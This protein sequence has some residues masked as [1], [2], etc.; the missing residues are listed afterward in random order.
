MR[1]NDKIFSQLNSKWASK[2]YPTKGST[3]GGNGCGACAVTHIAIEQSSKSDWTP[4]V[5]RKWMISHGYAVPG[6]GTRWEGINA[7]LKYIGHEKVVWIGRNDPMSLA[8]KELNKGNRIGVLLVSNGKTPNGTVWTSSG[9]YVAFTKYRLKN[10]LH[11]FYIKDSGGRQHNGWYTYEKSI[12][13]ALPQLWIV[14]KLPDK[15]DKM[16]K[17]ATKIANDNNFHYVK[18]NGKDP[19]TKQCPICHNFPKGKYYGFYCT[20]WPISVWHHGGGVNIKCDSAPNNGKIDKIYNAKTDAAALK[21]ARKY[22]GIK[23]IKVIRSKKAIP[24]SKLQPGDACYHFS[25]GSCLHAFLYVGNGYMIDANNVKDGIAKRKAMSCNVVVR[26][27]G[28]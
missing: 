21:L 22:F 26:Y 3:F 20:R 5:M 27:I 25:K 1:M 18:W 4:E 23:D 2:P 8:W 14:K 28:K 10:G 24:L 11:Q 9:H 19:K 15:Y 7:A 6:Q 13:G 12:K 17:W 16:V